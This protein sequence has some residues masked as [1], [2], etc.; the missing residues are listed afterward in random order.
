[1]QTFLRIVY[2]GPR[3]RQDLTN[4]L[5]D[6]AS[7]CGIVVSTGK[8]KNMT[9]FTN[10]IGADVSLNGQHVK[11]LSSFKYLGATLC[12]GGTPLGRNPHQD[13]LSNGSNGQSK[14]GL[15]KQHHKFASKFKL[16]KS[17]D[18]SALM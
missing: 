18:I 10:D 6:K 12:R 3:T 11:E 16:Y 8:S 9:N 5:V 4:R 15:P 13:L 7:T 1:M 17:L 2:P 14:Q